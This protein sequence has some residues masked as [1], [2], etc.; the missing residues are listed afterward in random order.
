MEELNYTIET[1]EDAIA[2][3]LAALLK[4]IKSIEKCI[5]EK[6]YFGYNADLLLKGHTARELAELTARVAQQQALLDVKRMLAKT[7]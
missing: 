5:A 6:Q 2:Y 1:N 4:D 7:K 3:A